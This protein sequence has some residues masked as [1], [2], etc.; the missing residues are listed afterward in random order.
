MLK[1]LHL[2][3][4]A[5]LCGAINFH[6]QT[7]PTNTRHL[8]PGGVGGVNGMSDLILWSKAENL[9]AAANLDPISTWADASGYSSD[10][11]Q[12]NTTL[13]P[14]FLEN[15]INSYNALRFDITAAATALDG[16]RLVKTSFT[17]FPT[18]A[19]SGFYINKTSDASDGV[20]S[21]ASSASNNNFLIFRSNSLRMYRNNPR[22]YSLSSN[23]GLWNI[24]GFG[25]AS[26]GGIS[27]MS[28]NGTN[29]ASVSSNQNGNSITAGGDFSLAGE[30]DG[31]SSPYSFDP[32]QAHQG[33]FA[34]VII[35]N[36]YINEAERII[37]SNYLS[38][39][40]NIAITTNDFYDEDTSGEDFDF[41]V[42]GIGQATDGSNHTDS[43]G[44]GIVRIYNP[45]ALANDEFLFWGRN[46]KDDLTFATNTNNYKERISAKWRVS[47]RNDVGNVSFILDLNGIDI[48]EKQSCANLNLVVDNDSDLLSPTTTYELTD[49]GGNLYKANNVVFADNDYFT[50]EYQDL[51]VVDNT[52]FYNG[53]GLVNVPDI[54]DDCYKLLVKSTADGT[55]PLTEDAD[56]REVE[57]ESGGKL[58]VNS[59]FRL[60]VENGLEI[61]G[62]LRL[63]GD[64]QLI[65][66]HTGTSLNTGTGNLFKDQNSDLASVYRYNYW[67]SPVDA[68]YTVAGV[69]KDGTTPTSA[70]SNPPD[71]SFTTGFDGSTGPLTLSSYWIYG[72]INGTDGSSWDQKFESGSFNA[73]EGF[74]LKSPGSAQNYTFKGMPNDGDI[75]FTIDADK[76]SLLGN[77][78]PSALDADQLFIESTNIAALYFWE[79][80]NELVSTGIEGHIQSGYIGGYST[81][82][83]AMG[84]AASA[85]VLGTAGLGGATYTAP[86]RYIPVGQGFFVET[87]SGLPATVNFT[88]NQRFYETEAGDS[89][90]F[91][92]EKIN[93]KQKQ[94]NNT[95][96]ILKIGFEAKNE[97]AIYLHHQIGISFKEGNTTGFDT[98]FDSEKYEIGV[99]D[100]YI[101]FPDI[102]E[103][104]VIAGI[105]S[106]K[107]DLQI[108]ITLKI[109]SIEDVF[110]MIDEKQ[111]I[112]RDIFLLDKE[113]DT[114]YTTEKPIKLNLLNGT[115]T[116]RFFITFIK[117][118]TSNEEDDTTL[119]EEDIVTQNFNYF[120]NPKSKQII[121]ENLGEG[122][123][124]KV[125]LFNLL[126]Q[127]V[128]PAN[129]INYKKNKIEINTAEISK[130]VYILSIK[131]NAGVVTKK[132]V[133][134]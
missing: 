130:T 91:K 119:G 70:V 51:I 106:I 37:V 94:E 84:T 38:A 22:T 42:A 123:V 121:I 93:N 132:I 75:T 21:Y 41:D 87:A 86:G 48:S 23:T 62:D 95:T 110:L 25:W 80:K 55:L 63:V 114:S 116:D 5:V 115:Y 57:I 50:I 82:N 128:I 78:Y 20:L 88:N 113:T 43:Q 64:S 67:S 24:V 109:N 31:S 97:Q 117:N 39:K 85:P 53:S 134:N 60:Q 133:L 34:E 68:T 11:T 13:Q 98:G 101:N 7:V 3:S 12:P 4:L 79:H 40:Y 16:K 83:A 36:T 104:L 99:S 89:F 125:T 44:T 105:G 103:N 18:T 100:I 45:S 54:S 15:N 58:V 19:I 14:L 90:F 46:N 32:G 81:R 73:G 9:S 108:P 126:G 102:K 61:N 96:P 74:L 2:I 35:Y 10:L 129:K 28:L 107:D 52:Q 69:M 65:Q 33:D 72:Y 92:S 56:V 66:K 8:G 76:T 6:A 59:G 77:P 124:L 49:V 29:G 111:H 30:Q 17:N 122:S 27:R 118:N 120:Y 71:L 26:A 112:N 127:E 47:K 1:K 131:T